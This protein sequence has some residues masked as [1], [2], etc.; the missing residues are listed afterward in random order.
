MQLPFSLEQF[1][2]VFRRY[3]ESVRGAPIVLTLVGVAAIGLASSDVRSRHRTVALVLAALWLWSGAVYQWGFFARINPAAWLFG[4]MFIVQALLLVVYGG[5]RERIVFAARRDGAS[6][7]GFLL[8][9][10]ALAIYPAL[11]WMLGHG[12]PAGPSFGAP[13]PTTIFFF[14]MALWAVD[15]MP[16]VVL[17]VPMLW[18]VVAT[19][20]ALELGMHEDFGLAVAAGIVFFEVTR[21]RVA[22]LNGLGDSSFARP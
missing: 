14:G 22:R 3:H 8:M 6:V 15:T 13:C 19:S 4:A 11:G 10:Y 2:E 5:V 21:R 7:L 1:L 16:A 18:A 20:A 17:V 9:L 12:Y